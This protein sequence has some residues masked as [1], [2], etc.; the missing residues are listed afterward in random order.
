MSEDSGLGSHLSVQGRL[1][2]EWGSVKEAR[3]K[4]RDPRWPGVKGL[5]GW[6]LVLT[7]FD[8][9]FS[10]LSIITNDNHDE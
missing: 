1:T 3:R 4:D 7:P 8:K 9:L 2:M 10:H 5:S 6:A